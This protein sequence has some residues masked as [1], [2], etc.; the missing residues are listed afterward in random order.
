LRKSKKTYV[1][2]GNIFD[3]QEGFVEI[4]SK[5]SRSEGSISVVPFGGYLEGSSSVKKAS[6]IAGVNFEGRNSKNTSPKCDTLLI[7]GVEG[8]FT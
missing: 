8:K 3:K 2:N 5:K 1:G 4:R 6:A 7:L